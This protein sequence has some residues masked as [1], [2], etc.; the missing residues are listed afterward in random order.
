MNFFMND[1]LSRNDGLSLIENDDK[2]DDFELLN[3]FHS[4]ILIIFL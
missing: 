4:P 2:E 3:V 1:S